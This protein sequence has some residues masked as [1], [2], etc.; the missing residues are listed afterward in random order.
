M[1]NELQNSDGI[2]KPR[3]GMLIEYNSKSI[4]VLKM[5]ILRMKNRMQT[6]FGKQCN[7][8]YRFIDILSFYKEYFW[9]KSNNHVPTITPFYIWPPDLYIDN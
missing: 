9:V 1:F 3:T 8:K 5:K 2:L 7:E 4:S 6:H